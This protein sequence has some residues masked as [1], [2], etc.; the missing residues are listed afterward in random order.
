MSIRWH[1]AISWNSNRGNRELKQRC[2]LAMHVNRK[3]G[4][5]TIYMPWCQQI[6]IAKFLFSYKDDLPK[7]FKPNLTAQSVADPGEGPGQPRSPPLFLDENEVRRAEKKFFGRPSPPLSQGLDDCPPPLI[8]RSGS[9]TAND[10]KSPLPVDLCR[11]KTPLLKLPNVFRM[12]SCDLVSGLWD[13]VKHP[14]PQDLVLR[15]IFYYSPPMGK[16]IQ[17]NAEGMPC[18]STLGLNIDWCISVGKI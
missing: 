2:F 9:A 8:W 16:E 1:E 7:S 6:C 11:L 18:P 4:L 3:W 15:P 12:A 13:L 10:A 17:S 14:H 5:L